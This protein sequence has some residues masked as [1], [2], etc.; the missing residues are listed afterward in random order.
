LVTIYAPNARNRL[1]AF[2]SW[3]RIRK[4]MARTAERICCKFTWTTCLVF[5]SNK[6]ECQGQ[7]SKVRVTR[8]KKT[9]YALT[10]PPQCGRN[11]TASLQIT[12]RTQQARGGLGR[13]PMAVPRISRF[14]FFNY[15]HPMEY[16][17]PSSFYLFS[18]PNL[19]G[20]RLD[21][22]HTSTHGMAF[23]T[24]GVALVRI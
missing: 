4:W 18:A 5:R 8:D 12:S 21:V 16:F 11:G 23:S 19:N 15:G 24:H 10:T 9:R 6:L 14:V 22:Y 17:C 1:N 20:L 2:D 7:K 3:T 13:L